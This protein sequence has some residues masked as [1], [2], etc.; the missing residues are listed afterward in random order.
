MSDT[1]NN[2]R[3]TKIDSARHCAEVDL[4]IPYDPLLTSSQ[5]MEVIAA[6]LTQHGLDTSDFSTPQAAQLLE[7]KVANILGVQSSIWFPTGTMAQGVAAKIYAT[8][9]PIDANKVLL[10]PTSHILLHEMEGY[11][12][13]YNLS[14]QLEGEWFAPMDENSLHQD[15]SCMFIEMPQR[16]SGGALPTWQTLERIKQ[17]SEHTN[18]KLHMDGARLWA[19]RPYYQDRS[20]ADILAG[21]DSAYV[22]F[23]KDIGALG[24]AMLIGTA[25]FIEQAKV[26]RTRLGGF[27][28]GSWPLIVDTLRVIDHKLEQMPKYVEKAI[29]MAESIAELDVEIFPDRPHINMFHLKLPFTKS[30]IEAARETVAK[31]QGVW[32]SD[33]I[34]DWNAPDYY[35]MEFVVGEHALNLD[36]DRFHQAI[37]ALLKHLHTNQEIA[38]T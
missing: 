18:V 1:K 3:S 12:H 10:H 13:L 25:E 27:S 30:A 24:G 33:R 20:Y 21:F 7:E 36:S 38:C 28:P 14:V 23:Y 26:W 9:A 37:S 32:L 16:H 17:Q 29:S 5:T 31:K 8:T 34:W 15:L 11:K 19:C 2:F 22:S 4:G 35:T 6:Y